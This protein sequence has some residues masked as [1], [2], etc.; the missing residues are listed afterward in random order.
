MDQW[1][2]EKTITEADRNLDYL[3]TTAEK[4]YNVVREIE[5]RIYRQFPHITPVLPEKLTFI[6]SEE[7]LQRYPDLTSREREASS[8]SNVRMA[9]MSVY[10]PKPGAIS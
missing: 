2:W 3:K 7:L 8:S 6:H 9:F 10:S 4:I 5:K 1:D